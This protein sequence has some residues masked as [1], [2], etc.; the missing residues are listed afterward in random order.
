[1]P[2]G[3]SSS[4]TYARSRRPPC[5]AGAPRRSFPSFWQELAGAPSTGRHRTSFPRPRL[6]RPSPPTTSTSSSRLRPQLTVS[7]S[8]PR[9]ERLHLVHCCSRRYTL[10]QARPCSAAPLLRPLPRPSPPRR[11]AAAVVARPPRRHHG[12][13]GPKMTT[14]A[15]LSLYH[16]GVRDHQV[17]RRSS[18]CTT[19]TPREPLPSTQGRQVP[20]RP[21]YDYVISP[22]TPRMRQVRL[23][24]PP[25]SSTDDSND[26][27]TCTTTVDPQRPRGRQ[28]LC[29]DPEHLRSMYHYFHYRRENDYFPYDT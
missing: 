1:M 18:P 25:S 21:V 8:C 2:E 6:W 20:L 17:P 14:A 9:I 22:S 24:G 26:Y 11:L 12:A 13:P 27:E 3:R 29:R 23:H 5:P 16:F 19:T 28:V 15:H 10:P 7:R 4:S